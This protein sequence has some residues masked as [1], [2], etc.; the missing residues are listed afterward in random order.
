MRHQ[1]PTH[2][3]HDT[4]RQRAAACLTTVL[5]GALGLSGATTAAWAG[6]DGNDV[7]DDPV[8]DLGVA[9]VAPNV[10]LSAVD[11]LADG[12]PVAYVFSD[13]EPVSLTVLDLR[14]G[15]VLDSHDMAPYSVAASIDVA[16]DHQ[17]YLSVRSPNDGTMWRYDPGAGELTEL[18]VGVAGEEMLR[19][20]DIVGDTL[21]GTTY[22]NAELYAMDLATAEFTEYG[23]VAEGSDYAWG[24]DVTDEG[25]WVGAG[26]PAQ[27]V[28]VD[29]GNGAMTPIELPENVTAAGDFV[30]R[31][32]SYRGVTAV[33]HRMVDDVNLS[34][35]DE[36]GW[37]DQIAVG[38]LW[39]YTE[40]A[41][42]GSFYYL[43]PEGTPT[44]YD[45]AERTAT[46]IDIDGSAIE[47]ATEGTSQLFLI[48]LGTDDFPG[49]S[50]VGVRTDG[51]IWRYSLRT[52]AA[53]LV[54]PDPFGSAVTVMS[55]AAGGDGEVYLGG[56]LSPGVMARVDPATGQVAQLDGPT[57]ADAIVAHQ[58]MT[59]VGTYPGASFF[60]TG[61]DG[62]WDW[63]EDPHQLFSLAEAG[64]DRPRHLVSAGDLVAA[65]T[66]ATYGQLG[67]ALTLFDPVTGAHETYRDVVPDQSV[68]D[69]AYAGGMIYG[70]SSVHGALDS[71]PV[72]TEAEL[73][74]W[75]I[76]AAEVVHSEVVIPGAEVIHAVAIDGTGTLWGM[77]DSG[78]L[79]SYD[80]V[81][82]SVQQVIETDLRN[83]NVWGSRSMLS[84][85]ETDGLIY[86]LAGGTLFRFDPEVPEPEVLQSG[87]IQE[88]A[89]AAGDLYYADTTNVYRYDLP[90][91]HCT[92]TITGTHRGAVRAEA[93]VWCVHDA[94]L[95]GSV[96]LGAGAT[97]QMQ[98]STMTGSLL[99]H[100][101][102]RIELRSSTITGSAHLSGTEG[103]IL[104]SGSTITGALA[105]HR[106]QQEPDDGGIPNELTGPVSGQCRVLLD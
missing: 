95:S 21:Y 54:H 76:A 85:R 42:D 60:A 38:G 41:V 23:T 91:D 39:L 51:T 43:D 11:V 89:L 16:E 36:S 10:R 72:A 99:A 83:T 59:V 1:P 40:D 84:Y 46:P 66:I 32:E 9:M 58:G 27:L 48:E 30:Q 24:L 80:T 64:Q 14:T 13:G 31:V 19:T 37:V 63:G 77:A 70:G 29:P 44:G 87:G 15:E 61:H 75:D 104:I 105:C 103:E 12:T 86:G 56:Y 90:G 78:E 79:F 52:G 50:L 73:F 62:G 4:I 18:A 81:T 88:A 93:G 94:E 98:D 96:I 101:A 69:L 82:R 33:S 65:G 71:D 100:R 35:R 3:R 55:L 67:G 6:P 22:P 26:T 68:T 92:E 47:G 20:I 28:Q 17:V 74:T 106:N 49:Q 7:S 2:T 102:A 34:L 57:Q 25:V 97:L 53:D 45:L 8:T 5:L